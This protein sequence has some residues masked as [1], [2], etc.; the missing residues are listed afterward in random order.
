MNII[1]LNNANLIVRNMGKLH[2]ILTH[3]SSTVPPGVHLLAGNS[4]LHVVSLM[5][6]IVRKTELQSGDIRVNGK[7]SWPTGRLGIFSSVVT[8]INAISHFSALYGIDRALT[9][10]FIREHFNN[11]DLLWEK[12]V[13]WPAQERAHFGLLLSLLPDFDIYLIDSNIAFTDDLEFSRKFIQLF[14]SRLQGKSALITAKQVQVVR[15]LCTS[16]VYV[17][18]GTVNVTRDVEDAL[19][20]NNSKPINIGSINETAEVDEDDGLLF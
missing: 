6:L 16:A 19:E 4:R 9:I 3:A 15:A 18:D 7:A 17:G 1:E 20:R 12:M 14:L 2:P 10:S 11:S 13:N 5:D 8:G